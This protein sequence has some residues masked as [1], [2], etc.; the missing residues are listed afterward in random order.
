M[1]YADNLVLMEEG[2]DEMR[3]MKRRLEGYLNRKCL[4]LNTEKTKIIRS[5]KG[6]RRW[7]KKDWKWKEKKLEE[8]RQYK[9]LVYVMQG[10]GGQKAL[11]WTVLS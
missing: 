9:Y 10:N 8:V 11:I 7:S 3:S 6:K 5:K 4:E 2:E 1:A